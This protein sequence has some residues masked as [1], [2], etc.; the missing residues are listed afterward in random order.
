MSAELDYRLPLQGT[1]L[2]KFSQA[3]TGRGWQLTLLTA[4]L[5]AAVY[6]KSAVGPLQETMRIALGLS[7]NQM[8]LL[9]GPA[10][11]LPM[12]L[13]GIPVGLLIDRQSRVRIMGLLTLLIMVGTGL[14][15]I[16]TD[17]ALLFAA[18]ALVGMAVFAT[19][20]T[21]LSL[22]A[23]LYPPAERGRA[24]IAT[25]VGQFAG[26][27]AAFAF[28]GALLTIS[29]GTTDSWRWAML[30]IT[31]PMVLVVLMM[32]ALREPPRTGRVLQNPSTRESF[33][34]FWRYRTVIAPLL[35][36]VVLAE[37]AIAASLVWAAPALARSF[38][39]A[40]GRVGAIIA[41]AIPTGGIVGSVAGGL[42][43]D[44][45]HRTGGP[46]RTIAVLSVIACVCVPASSFA[47]M[48][49]VELSS[50]CLVLLIATLTAICM[51]ATTLLTVVVPNELRGLCAGV[52]SGAGALLAVGLAPLLVSGLSGTLGGPPGI[53]KSLAM[54][55]TGASALC[56]LTF[57][58]EHRNL[59]RV[60][61]RSSV[62]Q[63]THG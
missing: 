22:I 30:W 34:E 59:S 61:P 6:A 42:I 50:I 41:F 11:G 14:T 26:V 49:T 46:R 43:A 45:C 35:A 47:I 62:Q 58:V 27:A 51:M 10:M 24:N 15:A 39:L 3:A 16:A 57:S 63:A 1:T 40:P 13:L 38:E 21:A 19:A 54:I 52:L 12:V 31:L 53:G 48:P 25:M 60:P 7:D 55:C 4:A 18:R 8:A 36:G 56:A 29:A 33:A 5:T 23:D 17:F 44:V 37:M 2:S 32:F 20:P 28:G 9:Q